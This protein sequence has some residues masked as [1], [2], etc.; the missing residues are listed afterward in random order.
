MTESRKLRVFLCHSSKDKPFIRD[1]Y[2]RLNDEGW[3]D[4]WL[5]EE[6]LL[7]GQDWDMEI[8]KAVES[9]DTVVVCLSN[10]S[11]SKEGYIQRELKFVLDIALEKPE[12]TIFI[13]PLRLDDCELPRRLRTWQYV[14]YFPA[15]RRKWAYQRLLQSLKIRFDESRAREATSEKTP[16][17][18]LESPAGKN[19]EKA[20]AIAQMPDRVTVSLPATPS[21]VLDLGWSIL[22]IIFF[23]L[24]SLYSFGY[25]DS[26]FLLFI[27]I[28]AVLTGFVLAL[29]RQIAVSKAVKFS[30]LL[31]IVT[32]SLLIYSD[33]TGW[34][35]SPILLILDGA[36]AVIAGGSRVR[37]FQA[38]R[39]PAVYS[40]VFFASFLAL[41]GVKL[42]LNY[43]NSYPTEI[44][45]PIIVLGII[46]SIFLWFEQ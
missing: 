45:T 5:D 16:S 4:P 15:D 14:N 37:N 21:G 41:Y 31:F 30:T 12:G 46:A 8:E 43:F 36:A 2:Q 1:L 17:F 24:I 19:E 25:G 38:P 44:Q 22:P 35:I 7:P 39:M 40:S 6:K 23:A 13:I 11:V 26:D 32:H 10:S 42:L 34:E 3:I 28:I 33:Y 29:N 18:E 27:G 9:A 20:P